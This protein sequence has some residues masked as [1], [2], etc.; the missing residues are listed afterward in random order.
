MIPRTFRLVNGNGASYDITS[1]QTFFHE[2]NGLGFGK[3]NS[4]HQVGS[5]Y[6]RVDSQPD[7][8]TVQGK[9]AFLGDDPYNDY[10]KFVSFC[11]IEPLYLF[12]TPDPDKDSAVSTS[13]RTYMLPVTVSRID[14][15]EIEKEGYLDCSITFE[16]MSPWIRYL[17]LDNGDQN[18]RV[19]PLTWGI[20]WGVRFGFNPFSGGITSD[21]N[22]T[23]PARLTIKGP[24]TNPTWGLYVNGNKVSDGAFDTATHGDFVLSKDEN[25]VIDNTVIPYSITKVNTVTGAVENVYQKTD[26]TTTRFINLNPG[27]NIVVIKDGNGQ[28]YYNARL[29]AYLYYD[30]V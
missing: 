2:P 17:E 21:G 29:E 30:T 11:Q 16:A 8:I 14:K 15:S 9:I 22:Q 28:S 18:K 5:R 27:K 3:N 26:F 4:Y 6:I 24:I 7:Q 1:K 23:S 10:F 13:G 25:L 20:T 12:Y 19:E